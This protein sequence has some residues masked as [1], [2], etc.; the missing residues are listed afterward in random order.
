MLRTRIGFKQ[1]EET[2]AERGRLNLSDLQRLAFANRIYAAEL[3]LD[4]FVP[5]CQRSVDVDILAGCE[6]LSRWDR[7][8]DLDSRGAVLFREF[9]NL[10][11][12]N[13]TQWAIPFDPRDPVNTPR[14]LLASS[15][16]PLLAA[17][18]SAVQALRA[19]FIPLDGTLGQF[20][21]EIRNGIRFPLHGGIGDIDGSYNSIHMRSGLQAGG[22]QD[23]AWGTSYVQTVGFDSQ[24]PVAYA[25]L[26]YGQSVDPASPHY[27]DQ[28]PLYSQKQ[29][30]RL[31]FS[32]AAIKADPA[33]RLIRLAE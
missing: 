27:A 30:P 2:I 10:A 4:E 14:G 25:M 29:W 24:G 19:N 11:A 6:V 1:L 3:T 18:K 33:Y 7:R 32:D 9:W 23:V 17:L 20:Q 21:V 16:Q 28:L 5:L 8:A 12:R 26:V 31:P 22:Y 15:S 13:G